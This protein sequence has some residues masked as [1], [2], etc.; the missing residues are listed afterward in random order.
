M[1]ATHL[2]FG[3]IRFQLQKR[4]PGVDADVLDSFINERY[5][6]VMRRGDWTRLRLQAVLQTVAPYESGTVAV[7]NG[8]DAVTLTDGTWLEEMTGRAFRIGV[9]PAYYQFTWVS[10]STG[11]LDRTYE[12]DDDDAAEYRIYQAVYSLPADLA[13]L[14]SMRVLDRPRDLDQVSQ[15]RLDEMDASRLAHGTPQRYAPHMDDLSDPPRRQVELHPA[16]DAAVA[17]PFWFTQDPA[18]FEVTATAS[19]VA[20][21]L[22]PDAIYHGVEAEVRRLEKD[23]AGFTAAESLFNV[24]LAEMFGAEARRTGPAGIKMAAR[25]TRQN[26]RRWQR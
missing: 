14:K 15:E 11:T 5:R 2:T 18:L 12:G 21:W 25:Y 23:Y 10:A 9:D 6:R 1:S 13:L 16:P 8:S 17:I 26:R 4:F 7:L 3:E 19:Y 20:A 22:N 24:D